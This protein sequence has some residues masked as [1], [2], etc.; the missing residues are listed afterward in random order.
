M[1]SEGHLLERRQAP[2]LPSNFSR[3]A[4]PVL[5]GWGLGAEGMGVQ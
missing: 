3:T 4:V 2:Y 1:L 5:D